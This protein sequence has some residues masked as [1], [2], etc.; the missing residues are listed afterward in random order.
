VQ[1]WTFVYVG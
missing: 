1:T